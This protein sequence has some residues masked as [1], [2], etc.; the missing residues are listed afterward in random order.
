MSSNYNSLNLFFQ[1][2]IS[3]VFSSQLQA[4]FKLADLASAKGKF[5]DLLR[6]YEKSISWYGAEFKHACTFLLNFRLEHV[7][8]FGHEL[9]ASNLDLYFSIDKLS[10]LVYNGMAL[11]SS[12]ELQKA[13]KK[14]LSSVRQQQDR[15]NLNPK[16]SKSI[17][18][19]SPEI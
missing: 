15:E 12:R 14:P 10:G 9:V 16:N 4:I 2:T 1:D 19:E 18:Q 13:L 17:R 6:K 3:I 8:N 5:I 7:K 11:E